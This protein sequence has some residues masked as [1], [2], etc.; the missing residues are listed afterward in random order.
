MP[1]RPAGARHARSQSLAA[2][3]VVGQ[4][5]GPSSHSA[6]TRGG[7]SAPSASYTSLSEW[8]L[9]DEEDARH[10][11]SRSAAKRP[12]AQHNHN[13]SSHHVRHVGS[14]HHPAPKSPSTSRGHDFEAYELDDDFEDDAS[15][16]AWRSTIESFDR[17]DVCMSMLFSDAEYG[18][19]ML[20]NIFPELREAAK[21]KRTPLVPMPVWDKDM[22]A[23]R[24]LDSAMARQRSILRRLQSPVDADALYAEEL[25]KN[26]KRGLNFSRASRHAAE[27]VMRVVDGLVADKVE[28]IRKVERRKAEEREMRRMIEGE[29]FPQAGTERRRRARRSAEPCL[30]IGSRFV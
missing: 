24:L 16:K 17:Q 8:E 19:E 30:N 6:H 22:K 15:E 27:K 25:D 10:R 4:I 5:S 3:G 26:L 12:Q 9:V 2:G 13:H 11:S 28:E 1:L 18:Q 29:V 23:S 21:N 14:L 20:F 7:P